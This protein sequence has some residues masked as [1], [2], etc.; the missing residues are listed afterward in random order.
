[1]IGTSACIDW[2]CTLWK[3]SAESVDVESERGFR[4]AVST[5]VGWLGM[6]AL[7]VGFDGGDVNSVNCGAAVADQPPAKLLIR[8]FFFLSKSPPYALPS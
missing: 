4:S 6:K 2:L 3:E 5:F 8:S 1:V 7:S